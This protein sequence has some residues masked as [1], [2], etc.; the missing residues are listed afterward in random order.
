MLQGRAQFV[1]WTQPH[2]ASAR[3]RR[4]LLMG[5]VSRKRAFAK[6][7]ILTE[8]SNQKLRDLMRRDDLVGAHIV[9]EAGL[10]GL[11]YQ[12]NSGE[13]WYLRLVRS[14]IIRLRGHVEEALAYIDSC[15]VLSPPQ[16]HDVL[17]VAGLKKTRGYCL[18]LLGRFP[19]SHALLQEAERLARDSGLLELQCEVHQCQ[20]MV[21]YLQQDYSSSDRFFRIILNA[22]EQ[23]G[24]WYFRANALWGIGKNLMIQGH[25]RAAIPWL[26][27]S[28]AL[29]ESVGAAL[30]IATVWSEL[31]VCHLGL[32][33]DR[34]SLD[35]LE[36][37]I[38][39]DQKAGAVHNYQVGLANIGNVYLHRGD[40]LR[41]IDY[42]RRALELA[43]E[44]KD[45]IS[46]EK[47]S[48]N[49]RLAYARFRTSVDRLDSRTV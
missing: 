47:W 28:L 45:P 4:L 25:H 41:A 22:S 36:R 17:S 37:A 12:A 15:E 2:L 38:Q 13:V 6:S 8:S 44:I 26:E 48:Y 32:G 46:I 23:I 40:H 3:I 10:Q 29:F 5:G 35:L 21:Y 20:A 39:I 11:E 33:D 14:D 49:I 30:S 43:R 31:A 34:K 27:N 1:R 7:V 19:L 9:V 24:G 18:G 42:Y 16:S